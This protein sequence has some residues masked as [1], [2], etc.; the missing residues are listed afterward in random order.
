MLGSAPTHLLDISEDNGDTVVVLD[1]NVPQTIGIV[2]VVP[3]IE[4]AGKVPRWL[5]QEASAGIICC[6]E[7]ME[8][9]R[10]RRAHCTVPWGNFKQPPG[11]KFSRSWYRSRLYREALLREAISSFLSL[12]LHPP[13]SPPYP[14]AQ[15]WRGRERGFCRRGQ[16]LLFG[17]VTL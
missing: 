4:R 15:S 12:S 10:A 8:M 14:A 7:E 13:P 11:Q 9:W 6:R 3:R 5:G 1:F 16:N 2:W 17:W